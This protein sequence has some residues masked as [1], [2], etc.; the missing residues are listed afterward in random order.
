[1]KKKHVVLLVCCFWC[2]SISSTESENNVE[3]KKET[4]LEGNNRGIVQEINAENKDF[5]SLVAKSFHPDNIPILQENK[6]NKVEKKEQPLEIVPNQDR[7]KITVDYLHNCCMVTDVR[8]IKAKRGLNKVRFEGIIPCDTS[9]IVLRTPSKG[10]ISVRNYTYNPPIRGYDELLRKLEGE[11]FSDQQNKRKVSLCIPNKSASLVMSSDKNSKYF[12]QND[13]SGIFPSGISC[14]AIDA[15]YSLDVF[16]DSD[17]SE[18]IEVEI[19]YTTSAI[20]QQCAYDVDIFEKFDRI[21]VCAKSILDNSTGVDIKNAIVLTKK[22]FL[23][24][25][26]VGL[27]NDIRV[28][29]VN[30]PRYGQT[31][32]VFPY[33]NAQHSIMYRVKIS[34]ND[35]ENSHRDSDKNSTSLAVRN[36]V[37]IENLGKNIANSRAFENAFVSVYYRQGDSRE[38][39]DRFK[40][41]DKQSQD[42]GL[43]IGETSDIIAKCQRIDRTESAKNQLDYGF[44]ISLQNN[45][46]EDVSVNVF[47]DI[48]PE[49]Y[50]ILRSNI[51][52]R[53][54]EWIVP[55]NA[56]E[57]KELQIRMRV[58]KK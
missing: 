58:E 57:F 45:K 5:N 16:F 31:V 42:W 30:L 56:G 28:N 35:L 15:M 32:C 10:R 18:E 4:S 51:D 34:Q 29:D 52:Q 49:K 27:Q 33:R 21:D 43:E 12:I 26:I 17:S 24:N 25:L 22:N 37:I 13:V 40:L 8:T 54:G 44:K 50:K 41:S 46:T 48:E 1:M 38:L 11:S 14:S 23:G 2:S 36:L 20:G 9:T 3:V 55:L 6:N 47:I 53:N 7:I 19:C 39:C